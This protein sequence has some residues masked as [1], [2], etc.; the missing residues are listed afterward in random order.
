MRRRARWLDESGGLDYIWRYREGRINV[1]DPISRAPQHFSLMR[2]PMHDAQGW[3]LHPCRPGAQCVPTDTMSTVCNS[4]LRRWSH[5]GAGPPV[6]STV[7]ACGLVAQGDALGQTT[8][9]NST[10]RR[11]C[12]KEGG[13]DTRRP[14]ENASCG[15]ML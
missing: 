4:S 2:S 15:T 8:T 6:P 5:L 11:V 12:F 9:R 3:A 7:A 14:S 13:S 1:A 10:K